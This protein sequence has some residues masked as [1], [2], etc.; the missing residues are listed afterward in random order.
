[1]TE[2]VFK[3]GATELGIL[4]SAAGIGA[5][6]GTILLQFFIKHFSKESIIIS[7]SLIFS[8]FI[9][10]FSFTTNYYVALGILFFASMALTTQMAL[11]NT[12]VQLTTVA[13]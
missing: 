1:M 11:T 4:F 3:K 5:L 6:I 12:T 7:A 10:I 9:I 8:M 2:Q 13:V